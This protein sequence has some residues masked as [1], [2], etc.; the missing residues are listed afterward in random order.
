[1][2]K[3]NQSATS[4]VG[5]LNK[6]DYKSILINAGLFGASAV[7]TYLISQISSFNLSEGLTLVITIV[8]GTLLKVIQK[9]LDGPKK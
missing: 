6:T 5:T 1:M 3:T 2:Q 7:I 8:L 9:L 4:P